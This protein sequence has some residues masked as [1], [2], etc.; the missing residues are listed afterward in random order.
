MQTLKTVFIEEKI[1]QK[2]TWKTVYGVVIQLILYSVQ[3]S[4]E[5]LYCRQ[6]LKVTVYTV[7]INSVL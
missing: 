1:P 4:A 3:Y 6:N 2:K 5:V 7:C